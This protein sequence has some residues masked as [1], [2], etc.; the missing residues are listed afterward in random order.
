MKRLTLIIVTMLLLFSLACG[1]PTKDRED[2]QGDT[3]AVATTETKTGDSDND[4]SSDA[5]PPENEE[6]ADTDDK[7]QDDDKESDAADPGQDVASDDVDFQVDVDAYSELESYRNEFVMTFK[8][9]D[10]T[11]DGS[12]QVIQEVT[13][14]PSAQHVLMTIMG[15]FPGA[16][17]MAE[18]M[19]DDQFEVEVFVVADTQWLRFGDM[20]IESSANDENAFDIDSLGGLNESLLDPNNLNELAAKNEL[21]FMG[22]EKVNDVQTRHYHANYNSLWSTLGIGSGEVEGGEADIWIATESDLPKFVVRMQFEV[23]GELDM[24]TEDAG[25]ANGTMT[26]NMDITNINQPLT[27]EVP[28]AALSSGPPEDIPDYP[29]A[30]DRNAFGTMLV[31]TTEDDE[32]TVKAFY[33]AAFP[34]NGWELSGDT[35]MGSSWTKDGRELSLMITYD[36]DSA[37]TS[38]MIMLDDGSGSE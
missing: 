19:E 10:E 32:A 15:M 29:N 38:I 31:I 4:K 3:T 25:P 37:T 35:F 12:M 26:F 20:W 11:T 6:A 16:D 27:I 23:T 2:D 13:A 7:A 5:Q 17:E 21:K 33:D 14:D 30:L 18:M 24:D 34:E 1:L 36:E 8:S 9:A 22:K 28:A